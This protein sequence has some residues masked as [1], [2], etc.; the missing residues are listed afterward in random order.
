M[1][2]HHQD[3]DPDLTPCDAAVEEAASAWIARLDGDLSP[4]EAA[5]F[6]KWEAADRRH[7]SEI[8]R[9]NAVWRSLDTLDEVPEIMALAQEL[10]Q[11]RERRRR[12]QPWKL[13]ALAAA[14]GLVLG[15]SALWFKAAAPDLTVAK[16]YPSYRVIPSAARRLVLADG[17]IAELNFNAAIAP[18]FSSDERRVRLIHGEARFT[19]VKNSAR[20]F[21]VQAG[22]VAVRAVGTAFNVRFDPAE[23]EVVVTEGRV[24]VDYSPHAESPA[25]NNSAGRGAAAIEPTM[26]GAGE[27]LTIQADT[28]SHVFSKNVSSADLDRALSWNG[29]QLVFERTPLAEAVAAFNSLNHRKLILGDAA[30]RTRKLGGSFRAD[31]LDTFVRLLEAG[32]AITAE[33]KN[34]NEI[35]LHAAK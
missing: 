31:N 33:Q 28:S 32:F 3:H 21:I 15:F 9:L 35:V 23:V 22:K 5:E 10:E 12:F 14:A 30:L 4:E 1:T 2:M 29:A 26:V 20:P 17:S 34:E 19:V 6:A 16:K 11:K 25:G 27:S 8:A 13:T 24:R 18:D 7:A